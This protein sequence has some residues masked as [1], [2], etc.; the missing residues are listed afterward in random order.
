MDRKAIEFIL[1]VLPEGRRIFYDFPDRYALLLLRY[2]IGES[3]CGVRELKA[4]RFAPLLRKPCVKNLMAKLGRSRIYSDDL[5]E[6]WPDNQEAYRLTMGTWPELGEK[7]GRRWA[8]VTR[9]GWS[10]V[11]QLNVTMS[12][13]RDLEKTIPDWQDRYVS[14]HPVAGEGELTLAWSRIDLDLETNE[15]LIEE[16]QSDWIHDVEYFAE[17]FWS[18]DQ[19]SWQAYF[20]GTLKP[21]AK[22]WPETM[23]TATIWFLLEELGI[24][25]IFYHTYETGSRLKRIDDF[26]PPRSIYT[27]LPRK[28]C[29][30]ITHNGPLFI[31][32]SSK[33]KL[34]RI[35]SDPETRW[36]VHDFSDEGLSL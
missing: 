15:A 1:S 5:L 31:R 36:Y 21:K 27:A 19:K 2:A 7:P 10:L 18:S 23:L 8:Q 29:F 25:T 12:H 30:E 24:E 32:D 17:S 14:F 6:A 22:K 28:F 4:S 11:L 20:E 16:V 34:K 33:R 26:F 9:W 3:G 35:F 13:R